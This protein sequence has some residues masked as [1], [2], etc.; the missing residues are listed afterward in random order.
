M[1]QIWTNSGDTA[2]QKSSGGLGGVWHTD[3]TDFAGVTLADKK[4]NV[5]TP[6]DYT[7]F[8]TD[9]HRWVIG[10]NI[11]AELTVLE[12]NLNVMSYV[13]YDNETDA[14]VGLTGDNPY[15]MNYLYDKKNFYSNPS[16]SM[17]P[18]FTVTDQI[19]IVRHGDG[20][21]HSKIQVL[22]YL[23]N[24]PNETYRVRFENLD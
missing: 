5:T 22:Q 10:M 3:S 14:D 1:R 21:R 2:S 23:R 17:P 15:S 4:E 20:V 6:F 16:G 18:S 13:G 19:Y 8:N 9:L 7:P 24:A 11:S 12:K